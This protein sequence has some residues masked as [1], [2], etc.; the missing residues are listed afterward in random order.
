LP[1]K[2]V[3]TQKLEDI[4]EQDWD[5]V[6]DVNLKGTFLCCQ[7]AIKYMAIKN[8]GRIVNMSSYSGRT[9][10]IVTGPPYAAAKGG[11]IAL[12]R[13]LALEVGSKGIT[14]NAVA[15]G[16]ILSG[17]RMIAL[18]DEL[19]EKQKEDVLA[20]IPL[21]RLSTAEEQAKVVMFLLSDGADYITGAV[22][23]VNGGRLMA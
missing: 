10:S 5:K 7:A 6:I 19:S 12:T 1:G 15:P 11:I 8:Y 14:V 2:S 22:I 13:R 3:Y 9:A 18:W 21:G 4:S 17:A 23:D 20:S 16:T